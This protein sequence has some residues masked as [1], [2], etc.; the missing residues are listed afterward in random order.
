MSRVVLPLLTILAFASGAVAQYQG[1]EARRVSV[2][3]L[4]RSSM[5]YNE[6]PVIT[7]GELTW[8][9]STDTNFNIFELRGDDALRGVRV[10]TAS[11]GM[12]DLRFMA[13][14]KGESQ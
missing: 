13:G 11:G 2:S 1:Q 4:V 8:G 9:D 3:E 6:S 14:Q 5:M 12:E 10:A 7:V